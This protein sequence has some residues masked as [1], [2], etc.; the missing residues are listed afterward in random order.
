MGRT[1]EF[2]LPL[3]IDDA[4]LTHGNL[5]RNSGGLSEGIIP[6]IVNGKPIHLANHGPIRVDHDHSIIDHLL[7]LIL[8]EIDPVDPL[9][10]RL[11]HVDFTNVLASILC[12]PVTG[13]PQDIGEQVKPGGQFLLPSR[14]PHPIL[15]HSCHTG[16]IKRLQF[17]LVA[18]LMDQRGILANGFLVLIHHRIEIGFNL[19]D[20][21]EFI[22]IIIEEMVHHRIP[23]HDHLH[24]GLDGL[25]LQGRGGKEVKWIVS[26]HFHNPVLEGP[27]KGQPHPGFDQRIQGVDDEIPSIGPEE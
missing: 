19:E 3:D 18:N 20:L 4:R 15:H 25:G 10:D 22:V 9:L 8:H 26:L 7:N 14:D 24:I 11:L 21:L 6:Q 27:L 16:P 23:N 17:L 5:S 2:S 1:A 13:F 12:R